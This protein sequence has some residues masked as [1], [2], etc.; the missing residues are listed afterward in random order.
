MIYVVEF[1]KRGCMWQ[2]EINLQGIEFKM[3]VEISFFFYVIKCFEREDKDVLQ[4]MLN[5][6]LDEVL[7]RLISNGFVW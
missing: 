2:S 7:Q 4:N 5:F 3:R 1:F 6:K